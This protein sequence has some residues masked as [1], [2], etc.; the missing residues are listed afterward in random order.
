MPIL[1]LF[2]NIYLSTYPLP[3]D[4]TNPDS[5]FQI[6]T[7]VVLILGGGLCKWKFPYST[8]MHN[9]LCVYYSPLYPKKLKWSN[10]LHTFLLSMLLMFSFYL[11]VFIPC[12]K[13]VPE[14][15]D[16]TMFQFRA[17]LQ[18]DVTSWHLGFSSF[19]ILVHFCPV[20]T[21]P[22]EHITNCFGS[23]N[24]ILPLENI[25]SQITD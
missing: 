17:N 20:V 2:S 15:Y 12:Y 3:L 8:S 6:M 7:Q 10:G 18:L 1:H 23:W 11:K 22:L 19:V 24:L 14:L 4:P 9:L 16:I 25:F 13:E 21:K 5:L